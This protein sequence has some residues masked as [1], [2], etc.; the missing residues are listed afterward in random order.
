MFI[1]SIVLDGFKSYGQRTEVTGFDEQFNAITGLNGSG[2]SN[3]LDA[4]CFVL[5][6]TNLTHV[7]AASLQDLIFKSGQGGV[8]KAT[9]SITF[10]NTNK[11]QCPPGFECYS[12]IVITR[13]VV[14]GGKNKY[15]MN[16][17]NVPNKKVQDL[18]CSIQLNVNNPHFL[19]MQGKITKVLN[20]KPPEILAM[21]EE[22]AGTR[23]YEVKRQ[24]SQKMMEKKEAK[25]EELSGILNEE[26]EPKLKRLREDREQ[27]LEFQ[28]IEREL[29]KLLVLHQYWQYF[30][31]KKALVSAE[32]KL[33]AGQEAKE[34]MEAQIQEYSDTIKNLE[35]DIEKITQSK[36]TDAADKLHEI[37]DELKKKEKEE[38][39]AN[40]SLKTIKDNINMEEKKKSQ[41]EKNLKDDTKSL[42]EKE[43]ELSK[44]QSLFETLKGNDEKD[45]EA[46]DLAQKKFE[47]LSAGMEVNE[48]GEAQTLQEQLMQA[49]GEASKVNTEIKQAL[50]QL[51]F[52]QSKLKDMQ[53]EGRQSTGD[54]QKDE[55]VAQKKEKELNILQ[56]RIGTLNYS[57]EKMDELVGKRRTLNNELR[58][59]RERV[60]NFYARRPYMNFQYTDPEPNFNRK[61]V[62][63]VV[64][65]LINVVD[66]NASLALETAA[67]GRLY[68]VVVDTEV[69]SK[70]LLQKGNLQQRTTFIPL[71]KIKGSKIDPSVVRYAQQLVGV[72][73]CRPALSLIEYDNGFQNVMEYVFG[74]VFICKDLDTAKKVT[75]HDR[76]RKRCVTLGGDVTDPGGTLSG[77]ATPKGG[78]VLMQLD[79]IKQF[80]DQLSVKEKELVKIEN[81]IQ[82][83]SSTQESYTTLQQQIDM[84]EHELRLVNQRLQN[85]S[86]H[87]H[88]EEMNNLKVQIDELQQQISACKDT[89]AKCRQ[90]AKELKDKMKDSK[91]Y[92]EKQLKEA[93]KEMKALKQK[94][95]KSRKAFKQ[96]EQ[97]YATLTLEISELK[98]GLDSIREQ[99]K[100]CEEAIE[101]YKQE[102]AE[103]STGITELKETVKTLQSEVKKAKAAIAEKNKDIQRKNHEKEKLQSKITELELKIKEHGHEF[104]SLQDAHKNAKRREE[105][106]LKKIKTDHTNYQKAAEMSSKEGLEL[107]SKIK[108]NQERKQKLSRIVNTK[109]QSMFEEEEKVYNELK[110]K[111]RLTEKDRDSIRDTIKDMDQQKE[112]ALNVAYKQVSKDFGSIFST[113]LPGANAKLV[114]PPGKSILQGL[115]VKV[116]LG[117]VWKESLTELSGGQRSLAALSLILAMLLFKPAPLYILDEVDAALDLS[118]T[119]NIGNMLKSHFK[120]S[121]FIIVS[122]KDGM[123]NNANVLFRTK[124]IDGV[125]TVARTVNRSR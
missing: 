72:E 52:C 8:N 86:H 36:A 4:I 6:I 119:Q 69:T 74:N 5:G 31:S 99:I 68:N 125:S 45:N 103:N 81:E 60:D 87:R 123:F 80:E 67:G 62:K 100:A 85:T 16:G 124:F 32:E 54:Y 33:D 26:V 53:K 82:R 38:A 83:M 75:F 27:F 89:E 64:A 66:K 94:A 98:K 79:D 28:Q 95:D 20:M 9:V 63:G 116:S 117:G 108:S 29:A 88:R 58:N 22:A 17:T 70:K 34:K 92:K 56:A 57:Q 76:I 105:E 49:E 78:S 41:L 48:E 113:L 96:R 3:I 122:L 102:Y 106:L 35:E 12:E 21:V 107:E 2:K 24:E 84:T 104:K 37:E 120:K 42:Q 101:K 111:M 91:G 25:L 18:F 118:H 14:M 90:K 46:F 1:K 39:K 10:D 97:D 115:E 23:M 47:A 19:I 112:N 30:Q 50:M 13:Q 114:P 40:A 7:R 43:Q 71:N 55:A 93:E 15:L 65:R 59:Q 73:N 109:A 11:S 44:D 77:G 61:S 110:K 51:E 121:Q